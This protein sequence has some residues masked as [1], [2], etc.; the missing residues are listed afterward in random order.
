MTNLI[1]GID[2]AGRGPVI[3]P[4]VLA[5]CLVEENVSSNISDDT[6]TEMNETIVNKLMIR[7]RMVGGASNCKTPSP[8]VRTNGAPRLVKKIASID[9]DNQ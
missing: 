8:V 3:G 9:N 6:E 4:M 7:P 5:G 1:L 2:D